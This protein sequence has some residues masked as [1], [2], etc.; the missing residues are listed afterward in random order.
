[1]A[2][3]IITQRQLLEAV[4]GLYRPRLDDFVASFNMWAVHFGIDTPLRTVHYLAQ[5]FH[6]SGNLRY[7]EENMN[8]SVDG[9]LKVFGKYF[10]TRAEAAAYA[11]KPEKIANR[12]YANRMGNGPESSGDGWKY[13]GRGFIGVTGRDNYRKYAE[14][15]WCVGD[16]MSRPDLLA[17]SPGNQKSA[18]FFWATNNCNRY[19]DA[20]DVKGLT[21][22]IN[23]GYNGLENRAE[24]TR[25]FRSVFGI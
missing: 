16:V 10:R 14:S 9:L 23:G 8:Y 17:G 18:M 24:L 12:V 22:R 3:V 19:A 15:D 25:R 20:D 7:T 1:M 11:R 21:R 6:E 5:V 13:R 4:P 2:A